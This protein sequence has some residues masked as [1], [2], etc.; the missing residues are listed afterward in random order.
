MVEFCRE[1]AIPH[2]VCGKVIVATH[3]D[4]LPRLENLRQRGEANGL[5]GL[6]LI[7]PDE[8][9]DIEPHAAGLQALVVPSTGITDY[10]VVCEKYAELISARGATV[11]SSAAATNIRRS[12]DEI[13]VET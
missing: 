5:T 9:R 13:V 10:A 7:G 3:P 6:R 8:L 4:E 12:S 1:H 11:L 2:N